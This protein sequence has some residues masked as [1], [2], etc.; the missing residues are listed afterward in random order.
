MSNNI[1]LIGFMGSG[2]TTIGHL[3]SE[4]LEYRF[5]DVDK[6]IEQDTKK[7]IPHIFAYGESYFRDLEADMIRRV[8]CFE[9]AVIST[10]G[11]AVIRSGNVGVLRRSGLVF[12]L[13]WPVE[14]LYE[15]VKDDTNRPLLNVPDPLSEMKRM[16]S[17]RETLYLSAAHIVIDCS[18]KQATTIADEIEACIV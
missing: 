9:N 10:G 12:Y 6:E 13:R 7:T 18:G 14:E 16:L 4:K 2:K 15:H 5:I 17:D 3:L 8:C 1:I 11:G